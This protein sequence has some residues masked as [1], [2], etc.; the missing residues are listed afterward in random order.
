MGLLGRI[1]GAVNTGLGGKPTPRRIRTRSTAAKP[2]RRARTTAAPPNRPQSARETAAEHEI[3]RIVALNTR[4]SRRT[5]AEDREFARLIEK[6]RNPVRLERK[7]ARV[8]ARKF[9]S[10]PGR[11]RRYVYG[12][13]SK[14]GL[15]HRNPTPVQSAQRASRTFHGEPG[16]VYRLDRTDRLGPPPVVV[17]LGTVEAIEYKPA[18]RSQRGRTTWRHASG[19]RGDN[20]PRSRK[21]PLLVADPQTGRAFI[22]PNGAPQKFSSKRGLVG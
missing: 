13:L 15:L 21:R 3:T 11:R 22:V 16:E 5:A 2:T 10:D 20:A 17:A 6:H 7:L 9:P 18:D 12:T 1:L 8:A 19:D 14:L 4:G